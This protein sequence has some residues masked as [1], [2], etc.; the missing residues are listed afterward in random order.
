MVG[1]VGTACLKDEA[2]FAEFYRRMFLIRCVEEE[3]IVRY[4]KQMMRCPVHLSIGQELPAV[5]VSMAL[6]PGDKVFSGHRCHAHYLA[7]G[8]DLRKM[9]A[10]LY[11]LPSGCCQGRGGSMHLVDEAAGY[12][13][14]TPIVGSCLPLALGMAM[15]M[16]IRG[17]DGRVVAFVGDAAPE[18]GQ[19]WETLNLA[20]MQRAPLLVVLEN[21]Q[22]ATA[23][24]ILQRQPQQTIWQRVRGF[25]LSA[26]YGT[27]SP[28]HL[29]ADIQELFGELP[30]FIEIP[31]YRYRAHVGMEYDWD[32][33]YRDR[34]EV[35]TAMAKDPL[36]L[37]RHEIPSYIGPNGMAEL[38]AKIRT[39][40]TE[41]FDDVEREAS[42]V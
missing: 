1:T 4:P 10:E 36:L 24:H 40:V 41:V 20:V 13:G 2:F 22:Y 34:L 8:G 17:E 21:N 7:V 11:G 5:A 27:G 37:L 32:K 3:I 15:A 30:A 26:H 28:A 42:F 9:V 35:E 23:T 18:T 12:M 39:R 33:G 14:T 38:E 19:F 25:G 31:T 16:R 6:K 29:T